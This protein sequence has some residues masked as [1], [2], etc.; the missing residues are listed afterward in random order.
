MLYRLKPLSANRAQL[1]RLFADR[2]AFL[3]FL[4][5]GP[6]GD[7][8]VHDIDVDAPISRLIPQAV[9]SLRK[10]GLVGDDLFG[11]LAEEFP[12]ASQSISS[13][14]SSWVPPVEDWRSTHSMSGP[15][16]P[17]LK[18]DR[19]RVFVSYSRRDSGFFDELVVHLSILQ[20][21]GIIDVW[22]E[23]RIRAGQSWKSE[24]AE[25]IELADVII[26][27]VSA[28]F[29][30]S[31]FCWD[32]ELTRILERQDRGEVEVLPV[33]VRVCAWSH[34]PLKALPMLPNDAVPIADRE[35]PDEAWVELARTVKSLVPKSTQVA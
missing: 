16:Q 25:Q 5:F 7:R 23:G 6:S 3:R 28:D 2:D 14:S 29:L 20:R 34:T 24:V 32:F 31:D 21:Q 12:E 19:L 10:R 35:S 4:R 33:L 13:L 1:F 9:D 22:H 18:S 8:V 30:A 15:A 11:R 17:D 27:L 26:L